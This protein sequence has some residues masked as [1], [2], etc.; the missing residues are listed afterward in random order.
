MTGGGTWTK[1]NVTANNSG[2]SKTGRTI[3]VQSGVKGI[4]EEE[5]ELHQQL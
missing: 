5:A 2:Q 1:K 3:E 4:K